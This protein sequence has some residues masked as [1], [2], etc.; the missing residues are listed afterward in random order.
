M[1]ARDGWTGNKKPT[2][3]IEIRS[4]DRQLRHTKRWNNRKRYAVSGEWNLRSQDRQLSYRERWNNRKRYA[5][6][7]EWDLRSED[8]QSSHKKQ[9]LDRKRYAVSGEW[10][11]RSED[12]Q[13]SHKKQ[14]L[15]KKRHDASAGSSEW[16]WRSQYR[17]LSNRKRGFDGT[18]T[19]I[20]IQSPSLLK[21]WSCYPRF[22]KTFN[23]GAKFTL[24]GEEIMRSNLYVFLLRA[25]EAR[26]NS[27]IISD[28]QRSSAIGTL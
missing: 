25:P 8:R 3:T 22:C 27:M 28:H 5:V 26:P 15:N 4:Q 19:E 21:G 24:V 12:R 6:S 23:Q 17:Q 7:G 14:C 11:S 20:N 16:D 9:W 18:N 1:Q 13:S 2:S 10:V